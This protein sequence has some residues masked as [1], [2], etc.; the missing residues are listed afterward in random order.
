[1]PVVE[2]RIRIEYSNLWRFSAARYWD[3]I[4]IAAADPVS[5]RS[6]RK[7]AKPSTTKLPSKV[8]SLPAG[9]NATITP[10]TISSRMAA[11]SMPLI[12]RSSRKAPTISSSMAPTASTISGSA[13]SS[14]GSSA[15]SVIGGFRGLCSMDQQGGGFR[16]P[17]SAVVVLEQL[18]DRSRRHVQ[19]R[20][21]ID[22]EQDGQHDQRPERD[23]LAVV[24]ILDRG[25]ARLDQRAEND[26]AVEP[27]RIGRRQDRPGGSE[28]R[29]PRIYPEGADQ[30]EELADEARGSRQSYIGEREHHEGRGVERH[31]VDEAAIGGD[32]ARMHAVVDHADAQ[33]QSRRHDAVRDHLEDAAGNALRRGCE[34]AH[35]DEA[36]MPYGGIGDELLHVLLHQRH[37]RGVDHRD[38][39]Q[40]EHERSEIVRGGREHR[41]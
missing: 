33:E 1:M 28:R 16:G 23:D 29:H 15:V 40:R 26:F 24:E 7:R 20:L 11:P 27:Q 10:A 6:L 3:D 39:R 35:G 22:A 19:H 9:S 21:G 12:A 25:Q 4:R 41:Q 31:A 38:D 17:Q 13:G 32:L 2:S 30:R 18:G 36:H 5:A 34:N 8:T 37:Q 14:A